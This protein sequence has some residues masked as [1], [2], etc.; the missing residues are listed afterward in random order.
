ME[1]EEMN[2]RN[3]QDEGVPEAGGN[4]LPDNT[5][6]DDGSYDAGKDEGYGGEEGSTEWTPGPDAKAT[7]SP[8]VKKLLDELTDDG[9]EGESE[10]ETA[11]DPSAAES[12]LKALSEKGRSDA[13][14]KGVRS[15]EEE[16]MELLRTVKSERGRER[17]KSIIS[18]RKEAESRLQE[19]ES[20]IESFKNII[21]STGMDT[22]DIAATLTY[23][24]LVSN[25]DPE[26][27]QKALNMIEREREQLCRRLGIEA[28]G[29]DLFADVPEIRTAL[30]RKELKKE[31]ALRLAQAERAER[32]VSERSREER[33]KVTRTMEAFS[34][35]AEFMKT[36][37]TCL[38]PYAGEADHP[39]KMQKIF[40]YMA[41]PGWSDD[42][43]ANVPRS[44]WVKHVKYLYDNLV[45]PPARPAVTAQPLRS[46]PVASGSRADNPNMSH[47]DRILRRIDEM[48]L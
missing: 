45:V 40:E 16:E 48:G 1:N 18:A 7:D 26:S 29:V 39:A 12:G 43:V 13:G 17:I 14:E 27:L 46:S 42:F 9:T 34:D 33:E 25:G 37:G 28:P 38:Q 21:R 22:E 15:A 24:R 41:S 20:S 11:E 10:P 44:M 19:S 4:D 3:W 36:V 30:E 2:E 47:A 31:H 32:A 8:N 5:G 23:G 6:A 35:I